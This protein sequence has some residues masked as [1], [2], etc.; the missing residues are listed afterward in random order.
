MRKLDA[1]KTVAGLYLASAGVLLPS[2]A[3]AD[4]KETFMQD[5][6]AF[7][8]LCDGQSKEALSRS[9]TNQWNALHHRQ[10]ALHLSNKDVNTLLGE[11]RRGLHG[12]GRGPWW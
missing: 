3:M 11:L 8:Q 10:D 4:D 1:V 7:Q 9:C 2:R 6:R 12:G 5:V